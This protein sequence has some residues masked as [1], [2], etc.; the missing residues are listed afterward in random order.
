MKTN[1]L[2]LIPV[3]DYGTPSGNYDG[4]SETT[5]SGDRQKAANYYRNPTNTQTV[6]FDVDEFVGT[7]TIQG[8][9]DKDPNSSSDWFDIYVF[10]TDDSGSLDGSTA[11]SADFST[12][13]TGKF[14]WLRATVSSFTGGTINFVNLIY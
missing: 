13:I 6:R 14:T 10:P 7:I 1:P 5:F 4:S 11:I 2:V 8:T 3:T 12:T 9:L